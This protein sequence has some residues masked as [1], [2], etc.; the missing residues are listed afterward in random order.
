MLQETRHFQEDTGTTSSGREKSDADDYRYFPEPD[1]APVSP[2]RE[3]VEELR[4]RC[5]SRRPYA[6]RGCRLTG[7]SP[8][9]TCA[10]RSAPVRST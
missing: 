7:A 6:V 9:S 8:T 3:W 5:P 10:T 1:L 4:A 2:S